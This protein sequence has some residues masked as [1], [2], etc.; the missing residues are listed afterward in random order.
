MDFMSLDI[1]GAELDVL[2]TIPFGKVNIKVLDIETNHVG[3]I[4]DGTREDL[5]QLLLDNGYQYYGRVAID[6]IFIRND[7]FQE[8]KGLGIV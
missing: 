3:Q 7:Y 5:Y 1:E 2:R 8:L 6:D 4:F